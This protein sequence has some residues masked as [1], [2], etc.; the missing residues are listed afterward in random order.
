MAKVEP[1]PVSHPFIAIAGSIATGKSGLVERLAGATDAIPLLE[2]IARNPY[3]ERFYGEPRRWAFHS[4]VAFAADALKRH[5]EAM[6][7]GPSIQDRTVYETVDVFGALLHELGHLST[8]DLRVLAEF[9]DCAAGLPRQ[10]T[11]LL[12]LHAPVDSILDRVA[13]RARPAE[14]SLTPDYLTALEKRYDR[15]VDSWD[16]CPVHRIDT[17]DRDL[18]SARELERLLEELELNTH[19]EGKVDQ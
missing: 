16:T 1:G 14:I 3:F 18:R 4:Q 15:F 13:A 12:Y 11:V 7:L 9:R 6:R 17:R 2:D 19:T 8:D 10:P 5:T